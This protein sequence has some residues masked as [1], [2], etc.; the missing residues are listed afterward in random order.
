MTYES[1][2]QARS[3]ATTASEPRTG[4]GVGLR[5]SRVPTTRLQR[6]S[7]TP[8]QIEMHPAC[9]GERRSRRQTYDM[10]RAKARSAPWYVRSMEGL[11]VGFIVAV[12][13]AG[14]QS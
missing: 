2:D 1:V 14:E 11:G 9:C 8:P 5:P 3:L 10:R 13:P 12:D 4:P 6:R 7:W